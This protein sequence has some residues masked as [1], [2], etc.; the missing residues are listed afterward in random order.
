MIGQDGPATHTR[1]NLK[2]SHLDLLW[3][4]VA[5]LI[6]RLDSHRLSIVFVDSLHSE[7]LVESLNKVTRSAFT[8]NTAPV[9]PLPSTLVVHHT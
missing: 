8:W 3:S 5:Q 4:H 2:F 1:T 9:A 6:K 7:V